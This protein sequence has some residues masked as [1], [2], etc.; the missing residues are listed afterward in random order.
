M[1]IMRIEGPARLEGVVK[2]QGSK[3]AALPMLAAAVITGRATVLENCPDIT[4]TDASIGI[5]RS[6]GCTVSRR[7]GRLI[8]ASDGELTYEIPREKMCRLRSSFLFT[9]A[10][11]ARCGRAICTYP[12]GCRIGARPINLHLDA[13]RRLGVD[14]RVDGERI[15]CRADSLRPADIYL[16]F[17]SVGA[18]ENIMLLASSIEGTTRIYG[19]ACE[20][21]VEDLQRLLCKMGV[22]IRGAG[23]PY[24][25]INGTKSFKDAHH[26][27][28]PDRVDAATFTAAVGCCGGEIELSEADVRV[29]SPFV[30]LLR[31][32]GMSFY[33]RRDG[34][35]T[36]IKNK[37]MRGGV[38]A[39]TAPYPGFATDMQSLLTAVLSLSEGVSLIREDIFENRFCMCSDLKRMGADICVTG[40]TASVRGVRRLKAADARACDLRSGAALAAAMLAA[41]GVSTLSGME[42]TD[43]GYEDLAARLRLLGAKAERIELD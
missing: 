7:G 29:M 13:F 39:R 20:P 42:F 23:T 30:A 8:I 4:D 35:L 24:V 25:E 16:S 27:V 37:R 12:G 18:T 19:A 5:L 14:V 1:E 15:E 17:P 41:D 36:V 26:R 38:C 10:L 2:I 22:R 11:L 34:S 32:C 31:R 33:T 21:E 9:G 3:N 28:M 6:L 40:K 43:R